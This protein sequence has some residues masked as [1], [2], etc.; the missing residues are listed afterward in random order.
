MPSTDLNER[1]RQALPY[2][3]QMSR[4]MALACA[5]D[6]YILADDIDNPFK[7]QAH[8]PTPSIWL[9]HEAPVLQGLLGTKV[10]SS[11]IAIQYSNNMFGA[12]KK[13]DVTED[14]SKFVPPSGFQPFKREEHAAILPILARK[15]K[16]RSRALKGNATMFFNENNDIERRA[17]ACGAYDQE[18]PQGDYFG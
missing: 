14:L 9:T 7:L 17:T 16:E 15:R 3:Q 10:V 12:I 4:A 2:F 11:L 18:A 6:V 13:K 8:E 1:K 5:G